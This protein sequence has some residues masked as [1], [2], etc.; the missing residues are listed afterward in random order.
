MTHAEL[1]A[2]ITHCRD[3]AQDP[4]A[5]PET[6]AQW[7]RF[8]EEAEVLQRVAGWVECF[9]AQVGEVSQ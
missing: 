6:A 3:A 1:A 9:G 7:E 4:K 8:A 2:H 5:D